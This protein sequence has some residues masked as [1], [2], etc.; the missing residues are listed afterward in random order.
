M[1]SEEVAA[2]A[3]SPR[4]GLVHVKTTTYELQKQFMSTDSESRL[5]GVCPDVFKSTAGTTTMASVSGCWNRGPGGHAIR[6]ATNAEMPILY[7]ILTSASFFGYLT[8]HTKHTSD[9][10]K[11]FQSLLWVVHPRSPS[12][13]PIETL[14]PSIDDH[15]PLLVQPLP[16]APDLLL[17]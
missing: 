15:L 6:W 10:A 17:G 8:C 2:A 13:G 1:S 12:D 14:N 3:V 5:H 9:N 16:H 11:Y 4:G 7:M